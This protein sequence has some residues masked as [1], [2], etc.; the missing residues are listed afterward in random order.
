MTSKLLQRIAKEVQGT[1]GVWETDGL[2][3]AYLAS[4]V[5]ANGVIVELGSARGR[6]AAYMAASLT[7][8]TNKP[9]DIIQSTYLIM[10]I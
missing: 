2:S 7:Y 10:T 8:G 1:M 5:P 9:K 6:S 4:K 3:L